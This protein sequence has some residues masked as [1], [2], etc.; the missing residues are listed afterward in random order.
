MEIFIGF[1]FKNMIM[2][3]KYPFPANAGYI[4]EKAGRHMGAPPKFL[5]YHMSR[6]I[7]YLQL[8]S[9]A[10]QTYH[11]KADFIVPIIQVLRV[12]NV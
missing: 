6:L 2:F 12:L 10:Q 4:L 7:S 5:K 9:Q 8:S 11:M 3:H 1:V